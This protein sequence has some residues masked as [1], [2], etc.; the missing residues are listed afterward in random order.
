MWITQLVALELKFNRSII[1]YECVG[2]STVAWMRQHCVGKPK[3]RFIMRKRVFT[4]FSQSAVIST[5][6]RSEKEK[7]YQAAGSA[8]SDQIIGDAEQRD[9][10]DLK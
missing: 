8:H 5:A 6:A 9:E 3:S 2:K 1:L 10:L 4:E 7:H